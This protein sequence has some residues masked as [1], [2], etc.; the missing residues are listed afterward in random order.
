MKHAQARFSHFLPTE[1]VDVTTR[2]HLD[3]ERIDFRAAPLQTERFTGGTSHARVEIHLYDAVLSN[4]RD[5]IAETARAVQGEN[6]PDALTQILSQTAAIENGLSRH[7]AVFG[8]QTG[9]DEVDACGTHEFLGTQ[10]IG[11]DISARSLV[12]E[13]LRGEDLVGAGFDHHARARLTY[14]LGGSR[15]IPFQRTGTGVEHDNPHA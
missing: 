13:F 11:E 4:M 9:H 2:R 14:I 15:D 3:L 10:R 5:P 7:A 1:V 12:L 6:R 8:A